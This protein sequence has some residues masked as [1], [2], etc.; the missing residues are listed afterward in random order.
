M[1]GES[2]AWNVVRC[3][4]GQLLP[5]AK[6]EPECKMVF[7]IIYA[8]LI[9]S[10]VQIARREVPFRRSSFAKLHKITAAK[11]IIVIESFMFM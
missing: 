11:P 7:I 1:S 10:W 5:T 3:S 9:V 8:S 2:L 6:L 4:W